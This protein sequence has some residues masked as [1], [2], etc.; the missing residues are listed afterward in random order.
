MEKRGQ[1]PWSTLI[2]WIIA[3]AVLVVSIIFFMVLRE[4]GTGALEYFKNLWRFR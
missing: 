3:I 2:P 4:K 1:I